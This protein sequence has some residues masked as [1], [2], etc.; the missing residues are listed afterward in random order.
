M[1]N[2]ILRRYSSDVGCRVQAM[3]AVADTLESRLWKFALAETA[4]RLFI[5]GAE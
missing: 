5:G 3:Q 2:E 4:T 1:H